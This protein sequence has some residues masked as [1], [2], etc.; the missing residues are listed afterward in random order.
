[1]EFFVCSHAAPHVA[2]L[3]D[4]PDLDETHWSYMDRFADHF[5][6]RGP[7]SQATTATAG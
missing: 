2:D 3:D 5:V 7:L 1:M 6:A 4:D